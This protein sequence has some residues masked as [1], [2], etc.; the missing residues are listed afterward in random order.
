MDTEDYVR[1][2]E[3]RDLIARAM[4]KVTPEARRALSRAFIITDLARDGALAEA[5]EGN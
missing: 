1:L 3:A 5:R 4:P 2:T